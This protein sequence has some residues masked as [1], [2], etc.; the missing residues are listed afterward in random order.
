MA[1]PRIVVLDND[2]TTGSYYELFAWYEWL[3]ESRL[4]PYLSVKELGVAF[5]RIL[6]VGRSF[7]PWTANFLRRLSALKEEDRLDYVV[8][9]TNQ[10]ERDDI[11][12]DMHGIPLSVP[13]LL[14]TAYNRLAGD[15][16]LIDLLLVR[17]HE[18]DRSSKAIGKNFKRIFEGLELHGPHSARNLLFFDDLEKGW[19]DS[20]GVQHARSAHVVVEPYTKNFNSKLVYNLMVETIRQARRRGSPQTLEER[21]YGLVHTHILTLAEMSLQEPKYVPP[22]SWTT[23]LPY[24]ELFDEEDN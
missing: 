24:L 6:D 18:F 15:N 5:A 11:P 21:A 9:Y 20:T 22:K 14:E 23:Y 19:I 13:R 2:A 17:P 16:C 10:S 8:I 4:G 1:S 3:L 12:K 7:R